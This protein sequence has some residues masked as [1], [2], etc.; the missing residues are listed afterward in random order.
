MRLRYFE[1]GEF[2]CKC[3]TCDHD[4]MMDMEFVLKLD[5]ARHEAGIPFKVNSGYR[6]PAWNQANGG[7]PTSSHILGLAADIEVKTSW[8]YFHTLKALIDVG[9]TRIGMGIK[10]IHVDADP[11]KP[12][13]LI[14][15]YPY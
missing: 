5:R 12:G 4:M 10:F 2:D 11:A 13:E 7:K 3:G 15:T 1:L 14:W 6:C 9:F 8:S